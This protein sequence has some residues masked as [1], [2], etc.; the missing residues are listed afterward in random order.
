MGGTGIEREVSLNSGRTVCDHL[1]T[2]RYDILP[3]FQ[4]RD[5]QLF[6]LPWYFLHRGKITDF[7]HRLEAEAEQI[8]WDDVPR[9]ID[10]AYI[11][12][13]GRYVEDGALQ[14]FFEVLGVPYLGSKVLASAVA[15]DKIVQ[16]TF[17][18]AA[19]IATP[20]WVAFASYE[21]SYALE[22][23]QQIH[24]RIVA[25]GLTYPFVVKPHKE[26]SS[27]GVSVVK[28]AED[29]LPAL[30]MARDITPGIQQ[31]VLVEEK[32]T[33]MEFA[34]ITIVDAQ[35]SEFTPLPPTEIVIEPS[36]E[37]LDYDQKYMPGRATKFTP[38]RCSAEDRTRIQQT[39]VRVTQE[40]GIATLSRI[41]G[42]LTPDG[43][44][45]IVDPN[46]F[47]GAAPSSFFFCQ[48]SEVGLNHTQLI[49]HLIETELKAYGMSL[50]ADSPTS[51]A[52]REERVRVAILMGGDSNEREVS[53]DSGRNVTYKL[54][55]HRYEA[56]PIFVD[57]QMRLFPLTAHQL[58]RNTTRE[59]RELL[60][61]AQ[62]IRWADL[63]AI[64]DFVFI[65]L[66]GGRGENGSV[67][68]AL[69]MLGMPYNGSSVLASALCLDKFKTNQFLAAR[70][71]AVPQNFL[72]AAEQWLMD[73]DA[74]LTQIAHLFMFPLIVKPHNDGC[75]VAVARV[76]SPEEL[77]HQLDM[78]LAQGR[79][80]ALV[81]ELVRGMELTV[82]VIGNEQPQALPPSMAVATRGVLSMEEK[83]LPG[84]GE[85]QTPAP[86]PPAA[87]DLVKRT[88]EQVFA[89]VG[90][91]GYA[92]ID[93]FY[94]APHESPTGAERVVILEINTLPGMTPATCI[95][96][97]AAELGIKPMDFVDM[98]VSLGF[99]RHGKYAERNADMQDQAGGVEA[100][101]LLGEHQVS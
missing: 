6:V 100:L 97:Q 40:L 78:L 57:D 88:V 18:E 59:V 72:L 41:D 29:L 33:G 21:I 80:H 45:L 36:A 19:G 86:L 56:L 77:A 34:C 85:N 95:F 65:A 75:S 24:E 82:G 83:F 53:F 50:H 43:R 32:I 60:N 37:I 20:R 5:G 81:E 31:A 90:C 51:T 13:H 9:L 54:S 12:M 14:G 91:T 55:P 30:V 27:L 1:D 87:L 15:M 48:G 39:C 62:Q 44:V 38:A 93:C 11:A 3:I 94:Q 61:P 67:Q 7:E 42:F 52:A 25:A 101:C 68:G 28:R 89:T 71:F 99:A 73:R 63:P 4:R 79:T 84:A 2:V 58:I 49:N 26:G 10:F 92:R 98:I 17:L 69:E 23:V 74:C 96:H 35:T 64:A 22:R 76:T 46:T 16:K 8:V 70:G 66:H 47:S